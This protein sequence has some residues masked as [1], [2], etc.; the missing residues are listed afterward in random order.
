M[1]KSKI[2]VID[3]DLKILRLIKNILEKN[4]YVVE[5]RNSVEDI[6]L[7]DFIGFDLN[8]LD[9]MMPVSGIDICSS[10][11]SQIQ[12]PIIFITAKNLEE[13]IVEAIG[14]G[15][16][17]FITKPF[18]MKELVARVK[19]HIR[20]D[21][22]L[23]S[24]GDTE[25]SGLLQFDRVGKELM[26]DGNSISLSRRE[27]NLLYLLFTYQTKIFSVEE[28][29]EYLYPQ[30]SE[31]QYR[32]ITEYIYQIRQKLKP[33]GID[34]IKTLWGGGYKWQKSITLKQL[35]RATYLKIIFQFLICICFFYIIPALFTAVE[36]INANNVNS[37]TMFFSVSS[38]IYLCVILVVIIVRNVQKLLYEI[39]IEMK[40]VYEQSLYSDNNKYSKP[41][42]LFEF[43]ETKEHIMKMQ[44]KIQK[45]LEKEKKQKQELMFRVSSAAHDLKTPL[46]IISGNAE[47]LQTFDLSP[48]LTQCLLDI[49]SSSQQ[50]DNYFNQFI[51]YSKTFYKDNINKEHITSEQLSTCLI[52]ELSPLTTGTCVLKVLNET[53]S[54]TTIYIDLVLFLRA[55]TNLVNNAMSYS[56]S[57]VPRIV[58]KLSYE[59]N[60]IVLSVWND[61]SRFSA[62][63]ID[64]VG[65][66]FYQDNQSE[67]DSQNHHFGIGLSFV[68]RV[69][70]LHDW[71]LRLS[72]ENNGAMVTIHIL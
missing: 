60:K 30:S 23:L 4:S 53:P 34:P 58:I 29:Y 36:G 47:Y 27:F 24:V 52:R 15:A 16:D 49:E 42:R 28:L 71:E 38:W 6:N 56:K 41:L 8:L 54:D 5:T 22:R 61:G 37:F 7:C 70:E 68:K 46:T 66:L 25:T 10:I 65:L 40:T 18:G 33:Y 50:L 39:Q 55:I 26:V 35:I 20:R 19:M 21:K 11:R 45:M 44:D 43:I 3:D 59:Q 63:M 69:V 2:L 57:T 12:T 17:D 9:I 13:D 32:S 51:Q 62:N 67:N 64:N 1:V 14:I 48:E 31:V 72:N